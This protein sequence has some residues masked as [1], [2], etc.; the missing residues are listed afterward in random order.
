M[1]AGTV[2][3]T[4]ARPGASRRVLVRAPASAQVFALDVWS[5]DLAPG[6]PVDMV[7]TADIAERLGLEVLDPDLDA[8]IAAE[9]E[10]VARA[11]SAD[12]FA[13]YRRYGA[14]ADRMLEDGKLAPDRAEYAAIGTSLEGR[15]IIAL[16]VGRGRGM[17]MIVNGAQHAREWIAAMTATCVADRLVRD[18]DTDPAVKAFVDSTDLW[19]VPVANPDGYEYTWTDNRLWRKNRRDGVGVD[20]NR[21]W[22]VAFG[23]AGSSGREGSEIYHGPHAFSE[24]ESAALRDLA[25]RTAPGLYIDFHSYGQLILY[26]WAHTYA[27]A[28]DRDR[29]AGVGDRMASAMFEK[30]EKKYRNES[31]AELYPAS[32]TTMDWMY[33]EKKALAYAIELRPKGG[34]G[35]ILPPEQIKPTCDEGL[36]AVLA[37]RSSVAP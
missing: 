19:I 30:H 11:T 17:P 18:Y 33:S 6:E 34:S 8:T 27:P 21:N 26:P 16:H 2:V 12:F 25:D 13:D 22:S 9:R 37:L 31:G 24:P 35:F 14:I 15:P 28:D 29:L 5:E 10:R 7:V 4:V 23:G 1:F 32:G 3:A 20:L 36:A